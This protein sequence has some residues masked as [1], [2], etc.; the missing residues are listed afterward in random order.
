M[1]IWGIS[2]NSHDAAISVMENGQLIFA[3]QSERYSK[4]KNDMH[5]HSELIIDALRSISLTC[6]EVKVSIQDKND[7][8]FAFLKPDLEMIIALHAI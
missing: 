2:A 3:A 8:S 4:K 6:L 1:I 5:L 7:F